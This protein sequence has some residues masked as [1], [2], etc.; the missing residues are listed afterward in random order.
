MPLRSTSCDWPLGPA[1][2]VQLHDE[3]A[4]HGS[5]VLRCLVETTV[6]HPNDVFDTCG[7]LIGDLR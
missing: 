5:S 1:W 2:T 3:Q 6:D 4:A 7:G